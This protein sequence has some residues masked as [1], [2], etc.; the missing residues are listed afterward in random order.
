[1]SQLSLSIFKEFLKAGMVSF[2]GAMPHVQRLVVEKRR[3]MDAN[4]FT[5]TVGI[6]QFIPGPSATNVSI[7][8]GQKID[9]LKGAIAASIGL[10][11]FPIC[12]ALIIASIFDLYAS[13]QIAKRV[14]HGM[15]LS[16]T[17]LLLAVG[18][19]LAHGIKINRIKAYSIVG[20]V[21]VM[22]GYFKSPLFV[23]I[24]GLLITSLI[25]TWF[26]IKRSKNAII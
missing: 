10:L 25:T 9:G 20:L 3:W 5:E 2:G 8:V 12:F 19:K 13:T 18:I 6:C 24:S 17:G 23:V 22:S 26:V 15:A 4:E 14:A 21:L 1:M 16:G 7:C 11:I